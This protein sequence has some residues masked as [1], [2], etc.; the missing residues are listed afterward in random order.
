MASVLPLRQGEYGG[1]TPRT[2][3]DVTNVKRPPTEAVLQEGHKQTGKENIFAPTTAIP[4]Q[5]R[6]W[7]E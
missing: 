1:S 3:D 7:R 2:N 4:K 5:M 6:A